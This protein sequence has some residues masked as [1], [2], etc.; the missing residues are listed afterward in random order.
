MTAV[1]TLDLWARKHPVSELG[2]S[3][4]RYH[5]ADIMSCANHREVV[6]FHTHIFRRGINEIIPEIP[7]TNRHLF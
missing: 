1:K 2:K 7:V 3:C 4:S 6:C 5:L